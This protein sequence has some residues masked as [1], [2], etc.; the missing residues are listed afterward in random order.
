[1]GALFLPGVGGRWEGDNG[2]LGSV[3]AS[4]GLGE[5][6]CGDVE[7]GP[8]SQSCCAFPRASCGAF[9]C[10]GV[11]VSLIRSVQTGSAFLP[12]PPHHHS[13]SASNRILSGVW[14]F[15]PRVW[16][17]GLCAGWG[18]QWVLLLTLLQGFSPFPSSV[19]FSSSFCPSDP[20]EVSDYPKAPLRISCK[21]REDE[22]VPSP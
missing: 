10:R 4:V 21:K 18:F 22:S 20:Q 5:W 8:C 12:L 15:S 9:K 19:S 1:M 14:V 6:S 13:L 7:P 16:L 3:P 17:W 2:T 11:R